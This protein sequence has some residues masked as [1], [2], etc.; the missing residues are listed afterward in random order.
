MAEITIYNRLAVLR[1]ERGMSRL[2]L[3]NAL[4]INYQ[5]VGYLERGEYNPSLELAFRLF[6]LDEPFE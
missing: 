1:A 5:T 2:N 4:G 6:E 3:A